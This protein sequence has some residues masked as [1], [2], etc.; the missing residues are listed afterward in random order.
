MHTNAD[1]MSDSIHL[2]QPDA[3]RTHST[4]RLLG[5]MAASLMVGAWAGSHFGTTP[6][7]PTVI[8]SAGNVQELAQII[9]KPRRGQ[10]SSTKEDCFGTGC[11]DVVGY[12]CYQTKPGAAKCLKNCTP[13]ATQLCT[14]PQSI[15]EHVLQDAS[16]VG[17]NLYCFSTGCCDVVGYTCYQTKPG[18]AKC[19][20]NCTPS[21]TQL[22]TQ[23]QSI[24]EPVLL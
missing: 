17:T 24:M 13:S 15:M 6:G 9:A 8:S 12:T 16:P 21:A 7:Q 3:R 22:C 14:Q 20:K 19:L 11:C 5:T 2:V 18:A 1:E 4:G 23:P 10:C